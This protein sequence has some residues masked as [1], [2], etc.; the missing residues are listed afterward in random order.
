MLR[1]QEPYVRQQ[2]KRVLAER[3]A[4][5]VV[6]AAEQFLQSYSERNEHHALEVLWIFESIRHV[7]ENLLKR[8]LTCEE[9][10]RIRAA[11]VRVLSHWHES[12]PDGQQLLAKAIIDDYPRVRLEAIRALADYPSPESEKLALQALDKPRDRFIDYALWLTTTELRSQWEP[13]LEK[14]TLT[15]SG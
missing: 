7:D 9:S 1:S 5:E 12:I 15:S 13:A 3:K 2:A 4:S 6:A 10:G 11:A 14:G 8:L